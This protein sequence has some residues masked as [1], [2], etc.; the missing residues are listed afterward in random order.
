MKITNH[1]RSPL[2]IPGHGMIAPGQSMPD[3]PES[4]KDNTVVAA[5]FKAGMLVENGEPAKPE[6][7]T[8]AAKPKPP[9]SR[10]VKETEIPDMDNVE[11]NGDG[12]EKDALIAKLA[13][14]GIDKTRRSSVAKLRE[15]LDEAQ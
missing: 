11:G 15:A 2:G 13:E 8:A 7:H 6:K 1:S 14:H 5:W 9:P 3:V 10:L 4:I 12:D